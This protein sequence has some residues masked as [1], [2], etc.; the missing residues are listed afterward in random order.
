MDWQEIINIGHGGLNTP[1]QR[2]VAG[3]AEKGV[4]PDEAIAASMKAGH[5]LAEKFRVAAIPPVANDQH[6]RSPSQNPPPPIK[7]KAFEG[8]AYPSAAAPIGNS[9]GNMV[10]GPINVFVAQLAGNPGQAGAEDEGF[11]DLV[12]AFGEAVDEVEQE[13]GVSL[14][15][16]ADVGNND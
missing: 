15:W 5:L 6:H 11:D 4:E 10:H 12:Q 2:L 13:A 16:A 9:S 3:G 14:H 1:G 8:F 7:I